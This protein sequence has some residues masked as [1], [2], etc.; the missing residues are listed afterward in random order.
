MFLPA[1][2]VRVCQADWD[3][4]MKLVTE[5]SSASCDG[6]SVYSSSLPPSPPPA[7]VVVHVASTAQPMSSTPP[8]APVPAA[9]VRVRCAVCWHCSCT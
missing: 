3:H 9:K 4:W 1:V 2:C 5:T 6:P 8:P 7:P